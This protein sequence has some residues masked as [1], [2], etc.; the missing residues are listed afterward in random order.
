MNDNIFR[1]DKF[2]VPDEAKDEF[3]SRV[4]DTHQL[5]R[6][7]PGFVR[8]FVVEK[9]DGNG[10]FNYV[11]TVEWESQKAISAAKIA[12]QSFHK[13]NDFDPQAFWERLGVQADLANYKAVDV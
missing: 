12:V 11:T 2:I 13:K 3:L 1:I 10:R 8:D 6:T 4:H 9:V 5:L 7:L